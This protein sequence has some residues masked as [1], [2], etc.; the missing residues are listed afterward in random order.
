MQTPKTSEL[1]RHP[2]VREHGERGAVV[3]GEAFLRAGVTEP[4]R[5]EALDEAILRRVDEQ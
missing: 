5:D 4:V 1:R 2:E 3:V